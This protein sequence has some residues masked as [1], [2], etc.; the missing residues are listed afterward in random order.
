MKAWL[1][2]FLHRVKVNNHL[3][4]PTSLLTIS[5]RWKIRRLRRNEKLYPYLE[6]SFISASCGPYSIFILSYM[7]TVLF[8]I[9]LIHILIL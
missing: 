3:D 1:K 2:A 7:A 8:S 9:I 5:T 6:M 4:R